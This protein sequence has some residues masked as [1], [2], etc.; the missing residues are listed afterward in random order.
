MF[1][2]LTS[3]LLYRPIVAAGLLALASL[4]WSAGVLAQP[5]APGKASQTP[6]A[7]LPMLMSNPSA[8]VDEFDVEH[9]G[10]S[11]PYVLRQDDDLTVLALDMGRDASLMACLTQSSLHRLV[12]LRVGQTIHVPAAHFRC[13]SASEGET[14]REI[15]QL[16]AVTVDAILETD[17][18]RLVDADQPLETGRRVLV[19]HARPVDLGAQRAESPMQQTAMQPAAWPYGDGH[20][21][22]PVEDGIISQGY[23]ATHKAL[24]IAVPIGSP[25]RA[26]DNGVVI[27]AGYSTV[28]YGGR[29]IIDHQIDY[30]THYAHL[31]QSLVEEGDVVVKGQI[32]GYVGSTGN[33]TGPHLHFELRDFGYLID[34][35][36][37][38]HDE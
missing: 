14:I 19:P 21:I 28:G 11:Q 17:W 32:I 33:S 34:P 12:D 7:Y 9:A 29:V 3:R 6:R 15:A 13:H 5:A 22:W 20:F 26:V 38:L 37:L 10:D 23:S 8:L 1:S 18:N 35:R 16:Y 25:V 36:P 4:V 31:R 2:S 30:T 27:K 24:D